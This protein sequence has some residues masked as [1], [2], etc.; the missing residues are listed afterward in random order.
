[1]SEDKVSLNKSKKLKKNYSLTGKENLAGYIFAAPVILGLLI[2]TVI[3]MLASLFLS[4]TDYNVIS[5][6]KM[7]G[8]QNYKNI[9]TEDFYFKKS[10]Q[11]TFTYVIGNTFFTLVGAIIAALLMNVKIK[12]QGVFRTLI[13]LPVVL[14]AVA[15]NILWS[16]LYNP[17]FGLLNMI[18]KFFHLPTSN[19]I[20]DE[21]SAIPSLFLM[22]VWACGGTA[23]IILA[24]LQDVP[25]DQLEAV[26]VDGGNWLHKFAYI[27]IPFISPIIFFNLVMGFIGAF[28]TFSQA[29]IMTGGGPNNAT[30]FYALLIYRKAFGENQFGYASALAWI[31]FVIVGFF[32]MFIFKTAKS[33]VFYGGEE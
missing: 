19:W 23:L 28:Q 31:M 13:Y 7:I 29:Y 17:D 15:S 14:P 32:T 4:F 1:M 26:E 18:L 5:D 6:F 10:L 3:P 21:S 25:Q 30:L 24:G 2:F 8:L 33:W 16:W 12:G 22:S 9:F 20:Y 11:V 27:T